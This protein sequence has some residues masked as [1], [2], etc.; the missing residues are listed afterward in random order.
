MKKSE[1][2]N[3]GKCAI[4]PPKKPEI[5]KHEKSKKLNYFVLF[6][7]HS[8]FFMRQ[9]FDVMLFSKTISFFLARSGY[10]KFCSKIFFRKKGYTAEISGE[11]ILKKIE[12]SK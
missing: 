8:N 1:K 9:L 12:K 2:N 5:A 4:S 10:L 11:K 6:V 7:A 3:A